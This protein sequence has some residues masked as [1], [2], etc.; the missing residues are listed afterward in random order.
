[1]GCL[2]ATGA[3]APTT[4]PTGPTDHQLE[5][6]LVKIDTAAAQIKDLSARF[7]QDKFTSLLKKPLV[8]SGTVRAAGS[9]I[10]WDTEEPEPCTLYADQ[11]RLLLYYPRQ[12]SEEV[13]PIDQEMG[14]LL[15]SPLPR[16]TAI[17]EHFK[18]ELG[19]VAE[20]SGEFAKAMSAHPEALPLQLTPDDPELA[21]HVQRVDVL[22]DPAT[23]LTLLVETLD[24]D[25]D[26][27]VISFSNVRRNVGLDVGQLELKVPA[28]TTISHPLDDAPAA[29]STK[30]SP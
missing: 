16:L 17:R 22:L 10:R 14:D 25:G 28:D 21:R 18:I 4:E 3:T 11:S 1:M 12:K 24:P 5:V 29:Q 27:T 30:P 13:Y 7:E 23:G 19:S 9:V 15:T 8:S 6:Q 2:L 26:R 20:L